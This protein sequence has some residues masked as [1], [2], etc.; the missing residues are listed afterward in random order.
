[1]WKTVMGQSPTKRLS[2][3]RSPSE[4]IWADNMKYK[5]YPYSGRGGTTNAKILR[6]EQAWYFLKT[7]TSIS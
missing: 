1:M 3:Q 7:E 6:L 4:E 5:S 2:D